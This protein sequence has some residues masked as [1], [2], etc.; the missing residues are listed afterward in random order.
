MK[1]LFI[2]HYKEQSGWGRAA[3]EYI[4]ALDAVGIDVVCRPVILNQTTSD[5]PDRIKELENKDVY[6]CNICIQCVLPHLLYYDGSFDRNICIPFIDTKRLKHHTWLKFM[7][8]FEIWSPCSVLSYN[9]IE[10]LNNR[11]ETVA[12][13]C[14]E[15]KYMST[16]KPIDLG[17][18]LGE[19]F[20]FY[21][22]FDMSPRKNLPTLLKAFHM[23]FKPYEDVQLIIKTSKA[24]SSPDLTKRYVMDMNN[25]ICKSL[26][27]YKTHRYTNPIIISEMLTD[28]QIEQLHAY[29][30]CFVLPTRGEAWCFPAFD[31]MGYGKHPIVT[32]RTSCSDYIVDTLDIETESGSLIKST[33]TPVTGMTDTFQELFTATELWE[34][35][36]VLDL[37]RLMRRAYDNR[38]SITQ[39]STSF[40]M[41]EAFSREKVGQKMKDILCTQK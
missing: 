25:K 32:G 9:L 22:I 4:L 15:S 6:D 19:S 14:D 27:L 5:I 41:V 8:L 13:P 16:V 40:D 37:Q 17:I 39:N 38:A 11:V 7:H 34:E 12:V 3:C 30:D 20:K 1:V 24:G 33:M 26:K 21:S 36:D 18:D 23:E 29:G 28:S 31:A 2:G 35:P 10:V